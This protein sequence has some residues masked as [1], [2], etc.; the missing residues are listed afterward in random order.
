MNEAEYEE[1]YSYFISKKTTD[2]N[3]GMQFIEE[4]L[5]QIKRSERGG[6]LIIDSIYSFMNACFESCNIDH[7][8]LEKTRKQADF[9]NRIRY[10]A[11]VSKT[12]VILINQASDNFDGRR[13]FP[14]GG[15]FIPALGPSWDL[16]MDETMEISKKGHVREIRILNSPKCKANS[17]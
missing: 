3:V 11:K 13:I 1:S 14:M 5:E 6:L 9:V 16:N 7:D 10:M 2:Y 12:A 4:V 17:K 8:N 15:N